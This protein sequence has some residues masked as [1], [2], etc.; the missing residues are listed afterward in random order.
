PKATPAFAPQKRR[1]SA[2]A[3]YCLNRSHDG[4]AAVGV[5]RLP[6]LCRPPPL[7]LS[8]LAAET[9]PAR[10]LQAR[11]TSTKK[12]PQVA[13]D[14]A[15]HSVRAARCATFPNGPHRVTPLTNRVAKFGCLRNNA[16][17]RLP[18]LRQPV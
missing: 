15:R 2:R 7:A 16:G 6:A 8:S 13:A 5:R 17:A 4:C 11:S 9:S 10:F 3:A 18:P 1:S 14:R 12:K